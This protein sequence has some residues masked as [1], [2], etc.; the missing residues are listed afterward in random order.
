M[1]DEALSLALARAREQKPHDAAQSRGFKGLKGLKVRENGNY[2]I[3]FR[4]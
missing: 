3:L 2:Y 1:G 4:V